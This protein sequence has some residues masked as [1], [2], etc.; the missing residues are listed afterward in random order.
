[1]HPLA[2]HATNIIVTQEDDGTAG[3]FI[4]SAATLPAPKPLESR[5]PISS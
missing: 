5:P 4:S 1:M 3:P 2:H